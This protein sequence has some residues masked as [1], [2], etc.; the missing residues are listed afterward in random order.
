MR[1]G[2]LLTALTAAILMQLPVASASAAEELPIGWTMSPSS[3]AADRVQFEVRYDEGRSHSQ[4]S[5]S[6]ALAELEGLSPA[7]LASAEGAPARFRIAREAGTLDCSGIV[8]QRRGTGDCRFAGNRAFVET[9]ARRGIGTPTVK[10]QFHLTMTNVGTPLLAELDRQGYSKPTLSQLVGLAI[11][12]VSVDY[13][14]GLDA[15]GYRV[16][17]PEKLTAMRIHGI[18]PEYIRELVSIHPRYRGIPADQLVAMRIHGVSAAKVRAFAEMGYSNLS[19]DELMQM[20]IH[21]VSADFARGMRE[22]GYQLSARDL[23]KM[24]IHGV[25]PRYVREM[26]EAGYRNLT[27]DQLLKLRIHGVSAETARRANA[28]LG[29]R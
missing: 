26:A 6:I 21:G 9:L 4:F 14:R 15:A 7:Q 29:N 17:S 22:A 1:P 23:V 12:G 28:A 5:N 3:K 20:S 10:Q 2:K 27:A 19:H 8:R 18:T 25:S 24:R 13:L 16:G 11:H